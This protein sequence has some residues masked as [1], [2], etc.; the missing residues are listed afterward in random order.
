MTE[1]VWLRS[2]ETGKVGKYPARFADRP[3]LEK[4][5]PDEAQCVDCWVVT[6]D[7][8]LTDMETDNFGLSQNV[9]DHE[10]EDRNEDD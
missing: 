3:T 8:A 7:E 2:T 9:L 5:D 10:D 4:I 6:E 1:F